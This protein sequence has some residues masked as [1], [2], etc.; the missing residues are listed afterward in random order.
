MKVKVVIYPEAFRLEKCR[1][2]AAWLIIIF[3]LFRSLDLCLKKIYSKLFWL[4]NISFVEFWTTWNS[5]RILVQVV[6]H[7]FSF[8]DWSF[9]MSMF[10][11]WR[12]LKLCLSNNPNISKILLRTY[13]V[14][15]FL[16]LL[17]IEVMIVL[18]SMHFNSIL[19]KNETICTKWILSRYQNW[20]NQVIFVVAIELTSFFYFHAIQ[21]RFWLFIIINDFWNFNFL[22][23]LLLTL[24]INY[25]DQTLNCDVMGDGTS[26]IRFLKNIVLLCCW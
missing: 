25:W 12:S 18:Y 8:L 14:L 22:S 24:L 6:L 5:K 19:F 13:L 15:T 23:K 1:Y 20:N 7:V 17:F 21:I 9:Q 3:C 11:W 4:W 16:G 2:C 10:L 26:L